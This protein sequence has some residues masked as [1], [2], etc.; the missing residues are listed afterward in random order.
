MQYTIL[1]NQQ[2]SVEWG[3]DLT[4]ATLFAF[5]YQV[6]SWADQEAKQGE[7]WFRISKAKLAAELPI[8]TDRPDTIYRQMKKLAEKGLI[9]LTS[10]GPKTLFRLTEEGK[11]WN[12]KVGRKSDVSADS[13]QQNLGCESEVTSDANPTYSPTTSDS[14]PSYLGSQ[15]E[16]TSDSDPTDHIT[17]SSNQSD[18]PIGGSSSDEPT[19]PM[20][21]GS[22]GG[23][24]ARN[25]YP[26]D[27]EKLWKEY[28]ARL[29]SNPK[30]K[31]FQ[32]W[33]ARLRGGASRQEII[34]G[35]R[36]Y[37][38][39]IRAAGDEN[40]P[41]VMQAKTFLG[42]DEHYLNPWTIPSG[43]SHENRRRHSES[44]SVADR[45]AIAN[46][47]QAGGRTFDG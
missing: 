44:L 11:K 15:S 14:D 4:L 7:P 42:P 10:S 19:P 46:G 35:V 39:F 29:G 33:R 27:F 47:Q 2:Q 18:K 31:A 6:P 1:I 37:A 9:E 32:C 5:L 23:Q 34:G 41:Y 36:R 13:Q 43:G 38:G 24:S 45:V 28:P 3:L 17:I 40:T 21:P 20:N 22:S 30:R 12:R 26:Q 16:L 8:L 25:D